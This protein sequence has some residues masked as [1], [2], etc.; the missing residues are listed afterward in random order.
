MTTYSWPTL[1]L[2][3]S[4]TTFSFINYSATAACAFTFHGDFIELKWVGLPTLGIQTVYVDGQAQ[5][6]CDQYAAGLTTGMTQTWSGF[7]PGTHTFLMMPSG[8]KNTN[9]TNRY[10]DVDAFGYGSPPT[11]YEN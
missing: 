3:V 11:W 6:S 2:S 9:A 10:M 1:T 4:G 8:N 5:A 7:G